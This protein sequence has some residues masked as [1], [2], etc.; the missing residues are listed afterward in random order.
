MSE[1]IELEYEWGE[2]EHWIWRDEQGLPRSNA[3]DYDLGE[4]VLRLAAQ[5]SAQAAEI[6]RLEKILKRARYYVNNAVDDSDEYSFIGRQEAGE[7]VL[8]I[9]AALAALEPK[10]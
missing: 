8:E 10:P 6:E 4:E 1:K 3:P 2:G 9:D 5:V 7:I